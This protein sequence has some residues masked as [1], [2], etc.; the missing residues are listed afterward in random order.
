MNHMEVDDIHNSSKKN[1]KF[2]INLRS[3][4]KEIHHRRININHSKKIHN[5]AKKFNIS[6]PQKLF[7]EKRNIDKSKKTIK[8]EN[9]I[10]VGSNKV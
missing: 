6:L 1:R 4:D 8:K 10:S 2:N 9:T 5:S 7:P 3:L